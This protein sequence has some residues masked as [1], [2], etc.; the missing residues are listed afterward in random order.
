MI[1]CVTM[2]PEATWS[3][4]Q[5]LYDGQKLHALILIPGPGIPRFLTQGHPHTL[6]AQGLPSTSSSV[7]AVRSMSHAGLGE[8][9][10]SWG[11]DSGVNHQ[12]E[13]YS[14][15]WVVQPTSRSRG[16]LSHRGIGSIL[17]PPDDVPEQS[18]LVRTDFLVTTIPPLNETIPFSA[19]KGTPGPSYANQGQPSLPNLDLCCFWCQD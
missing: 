18:P 2:P 12:E 10:C 9:V 17:S 7:P 16:D 8:K 13:E 3:P 5:C 19:G 11:R 6:T 4:C 15:G 1:Q 14:C